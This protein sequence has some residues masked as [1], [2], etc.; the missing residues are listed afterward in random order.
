MQRNFEH[1]FDPS[2]FKRL[3]EAEEKHFWFEVRRKWIFDKISKFAPPPATVLEVGCGTGN[4]SSFL[5]SKGYEVTGCELYQ[6]AI[7][8]AW[9]GFRIIQSDANALPFPE[10]SFDIVCLFDVIEHFSDDISP[11][12]EASRVLKTEGV[13][14][15]TVPARE[16]LWSQY[17]DTSMHKR[18]YTKKT[19]KD[20]FLNAGL[21]PLLVEYMFLSLY[22]PM[23]YLRSKGMP[24]GDK[25]KISGLFNTFLKGIFNTERLISKF[26]PLPLGTSLISIAKRMT[27]EAL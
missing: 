12:R 1:T 25:F 4:V 21:E 7:E 2:A 15:V 5:A 16:E 20:V 11:L 14:A 26:L 24:A 13:V 10:R 8:L 6:E 9:P 23:R 27:K 17:D 18:R 22:L 19:L 3:R